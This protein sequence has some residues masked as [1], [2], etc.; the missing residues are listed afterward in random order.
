MRPSFPTPQCLRPKC[1][2]SRFL[3]HT[4]RNR[5]KFQAS[6]SYRIGGESRQVLYRNRVIF[7]HR[8]KRNYWSFWMV[9]LECFEDSSDTPSF[10]I[11]TWLHQYCASPFLNSAYRS[12]SNTIWSLNNEVLTYND[13]RINF[14]SSDKFHGNVSVNDFAFPRRPQEHLQ[15]L[16]CFLRSC[17]FARVW[18]NPLTCQILYHDSVSEIVS[19]LTSF[20]KNFVTCCYQVTNIFCTRY[21]S[22]IA[23]S[24][25]APCYSSCRF[26]SF[27]PSGSEYE[28][29]A[30][31]NPHVSWMWALKT[32]H[33]K[34]WRVSLCVQDEIFSE[35][36]TS[37][38]NRSHRSKSWFSFLFGF[39]FLAGLVNNRSHHSIRS[40][41]ELDIDT[42]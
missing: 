31:P 25:R 19:I 8:T 33:E 40:T 10:F 15:A 28:H 22:A 21:G 7:D 37:E 34:N 12:F 23:S 24:A 13:S 9:R 29:C 27:G 32:L 38:F 41:C 5:G 4:R 3:S 16:F 18:L 36:L 1:L 6:L 26:R 2:F 39:G 20:T 14:T 11:Q 35:F 30:Y 17:C 42:G